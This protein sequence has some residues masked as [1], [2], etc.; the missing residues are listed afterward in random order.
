MKMA[1]VKK[2]WRKIWNGSLPQSPLKDLTLQTPSFQ[3][4]SLQ[5]HGRC[6]Q[7]RKTTFI[8]LKEKGILVAQL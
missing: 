5:N 8:A 2:P 3:T 7:G 6:F 1:I 4:S